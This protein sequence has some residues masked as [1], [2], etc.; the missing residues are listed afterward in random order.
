MILKYIHTK[1]MK[2]EISSINSKSDDCT[3]FC[4][5]A[6]HSHT[7]ISQI[8]TWK[9]PIT[10]TVP[11]CTGAA[12]D[13]L[14]LFFKTVLRLKLSPWNFPTLAYSLKKMF[15][16]LKVDFAYVCVFR[17]SVGADRTGGDS[18]GSCCAEGRTGDSKAAIR[19]TMH[20]HTHTHTLIHSFSLAGGWDL[21]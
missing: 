17:A 16:N 21:S 5:T 6:S 8:E 4:P 19:W 14:H 1:W 11:W 9:L 18:R 15:N 7:V 20:T 10:T 12:G 2:D 13:L 3:K